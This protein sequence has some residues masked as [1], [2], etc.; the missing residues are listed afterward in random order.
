MKY[1]GSKSRIKKEILPIIQ[2]VIDDNNITMYI[3]PFDG[4]CNVI[5]SIKCKTRI[6]NDLS[7]PLIE[8]W[9]AIQRG[10]N[11][12]L[13]VSKELYDDVRSNQ[14]GIKYPMWYVGAIGY[15]ASYN[16]RYFDGGYAKEGID[17]GRVRNYYNEAKNNILAQ[18]ELVADI[19]FTNKDYK[20]MKQIKGSLIYC[21]IPY[22]NTKQYNISKNFDYEVFWNWVRDF[23]K[24]NIVIVSELQAP[25]D[26]V[27]IWEK[28]VLRSIKSTDKSRANEK[29]FVHKSL[30][31]KIKK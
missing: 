12:P 14:D 18:T 29:M 13:E 15:L 8:L 5:D 16:G 26:F 2:K 4:G 3:E 23:S 19:I 27:C 17:K 28:S 11:L 31:E 25:N 24:D 1:M 10:E 9:K 7:T 21:D 20:Q 6:A 22:E 30:V